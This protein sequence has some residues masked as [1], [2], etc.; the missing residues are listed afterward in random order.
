MKL[1]ALGLA[2]LLLA[3]CV[4][5]RKA[6]FVEAAR[7]PAIREVRAAGDTL[8][9]M[10]TQD[11]PGV[12]IAGVEAES[13]QGDVYLRTTKISSVVHATEF[14][15]DMSGKDI[16]GDWKKRLYWVVGESV[17]SPVNPFATPSRE[18]RRSKIEL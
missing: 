14:Q 8:H 12:W 15:V 7:P 16:P 1:S 2:S 9:V 4:T 11:T 10:V 5:P 18:I 13:I 3:S 17:S 6:T